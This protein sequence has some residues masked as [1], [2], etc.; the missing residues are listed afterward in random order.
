MLLADGIAEV[1]SRSRTQKQLVNRQVPTSI[2]REFSYHEIDEFFFAKRDAERGWIDLLGRDKRGQVGF[3]A[4]FG[5]ANRSLGAMPTALS[6]HGAAYPSEIT[7]SCRN[8]N[9]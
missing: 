3:L 8:T 5:L 7:I 1:Q 2:V 9:R 6:G 4:F